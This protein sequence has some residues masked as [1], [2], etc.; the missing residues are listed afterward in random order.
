MNKTLPV[1]PQMLNNASGGTR[2]QQN[3]KALYSNCEQ[4]IHYH[5]DLYNCH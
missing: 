1:I 5:A 4:P 3:V 2:Q